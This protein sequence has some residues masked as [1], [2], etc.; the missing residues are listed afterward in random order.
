MNNFDGSK[1]I[2]LFD[3]RVYIF[4]FCFVIFY[5]NSPIFLIGIIILIRISFSSFFSLKKENLISSKKQPNI[6]HIFIIWF[7]W[8]RDD[9]GWWKINFVSN[10]SR[11]RSCLFLNCKFFSWGITFRKK[12]EDTKF[13]HFQNVVDTQGSQYYK[14]M[15]QVSQLLNLGNFWRNLW[16]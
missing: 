3:V 12:F 8:I 11:M 10:K 2:L 4:R 1:P 14:F 15:I 16:N 9:Q 7:D 13:Y 6:L 5:S